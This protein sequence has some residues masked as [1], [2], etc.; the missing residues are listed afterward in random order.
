MDSIQ[1]QRHRLL[2]IP[3][4]NWRRCWRWHPKSLSFVPAANDATM[5][6]DRRTPSLPGY[7]QQAGGT[8]PTGMHHCFFDMRRIL[9]GIAYDEF[10]RKVDVDIPCPCRIR[11]T[12]F[13]LSL[14]EWTL[15]DGS[16]LRSACGSC[17]Q[18]LDIVHTKGHR[19][20]IFS[21][22][23]SCRFHTNW[24]QISKN[25][26][27]FA[28][29]LCEWTLNTKRSTFKRTLRLCPYIWYGIN[30]TTHTH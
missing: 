8:Y 15:N 25:K 6:W 10:H 17:K 30:S 14:C 29:P 3:S 28:I 16:L 18:A 1:L 11:M 22:E 4:K 26:T 27:E 12:F 24:Q 23:I 21:C 7:G 19:Y 13:A 20:K 5:P 2:R 9:F